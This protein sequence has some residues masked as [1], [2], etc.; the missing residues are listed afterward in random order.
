MP[1]QNPKEMETAQ[2]KDLLQTAAPEAGDDNRG[3]TIVMTGVSGKKITAD[4]KVVKVK[5]AAKRVASPTVAEEEPTESNAAPAS[6]QEPSEKTVAAAEPVAPVQ[7][8][9]VEEKLVSEEKQTTVT[10]SSKPASAPV[11]PVKTESET[12]AAQEGDKAEKKSSTVPIEAE[13]SQPPVEVQTEVEEPK[14]ASTSRS[15]TPKEQPAPVQEVPQS[16]KPTES[17]KSAQKDVSEHTPVEKPVK[18][19]EVASQPPRK[20]APEKSSAKETP[21]QSAPAPTKQA[22]I[23]QQAPSANKSKPAAQ[24]TA[25]AAPAATAATP[26]SAQPAGTKV[27]P[28]KSGLAATAAYF[29]ARAAARKKEAE[30]RIQQAG[31]RGNRNGGG[32]NSG[33][34]SYGNNRGDRNNG[35]RF[36]AKDKDEEPKLQS[37]SRTPARRPNP[38]D[39]EL[40][41]NSKEN[42]RNAFASRDS[43]GRNDR[44]GDRR[45]QEGKSTRSALARGRRYEDVDDEMQRGRR[46]GAKKRDKAAPV[47]HAVLTNITLPEVITVKEFAEAIKKTSA[48]VIK[49]LM[50]LGMM[51]TLNQEIDFDTAAIIAGEFNITAEKLVEVTE[52]DILF[53]ES[54]DREEDLE[55]RPPVV[56]VMGHVDHGKTSLLDYIRSADVAQGE[57]GGITQHIG[58]YMVD[59]NGRKI[60]FLDTPGHEAFTTMRARGAQATDIAILVVAADDGVM[61]Q[62]IEAINHAKA[63]GTQVVVAINKMDRPGANPDRVKEELSQH[64]L[65][66]EEWG[67]TTVMVPV[68]AKTGEGIEDLLEMVLLTADVLELKANPNRQA[69]GIVIE[70]KLDKQRGPVATLLVNRG[71]LR[72]GDTVVM[73]EIVGR[74]RAMTDAKGQQRKEAG[75]SVPVEIIGI[76]EVPTAGDVFYQVENEKV[77]RSLAEK[78]RVQN[79]ERS[80]QGSSRMS[81]DNL[82]SQMEAGEVKDLNLIVKADVQGSVEAVNQ[83]MLKLSNDE[84]KVKIVHSAVGAITES[85]LNLAEVANAIVIGFNVRPSANVA[86]QAKN[87]GIDL[88]L[89]RVIYHAIEEI[90]AA[91]KG[92]LTPKLEEVTLGTVEIRQVFRASN[93]GTIGG[94]YVTHGK[95]VRNCRARLVRDGVQIWDGKLAS[96][97]RFKDDVREVAQGYECG[98]SLE[99][100]ND[101]KEGDLIETY[102][103]QE[104]ERE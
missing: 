57:A 35:P 30:Q 73:G 32:R 29:A 36:S 26:N 65:I 9:S 96:L 75:P 16:V 62:T 19:V 103:M 24:S 81:L 88:R 7:A 27:D 23:P 77:A 61:P 53:D 54:D 51:A 67:G 64:E 98:I 97:K 79:R 17:E 86:D 59:L 4:V 10:G 60:T 5:K 95:V 34:N 58:A 44:R 74:V 47:I 84:V 25:P 46:R 90:E 3:P 39:Q 50:K 83:A 94:G 28:A 99:N 40:L 78:R 13:T 85:D 41:G 2:E 56:C 1:N 104:V 101:I 100:F 70:A 22:P 52:E 14:S 68:S 69:K 91:M 82:F 72:V 48:E 87:A 31:Q 15:E 6:N 20:P 37:H 63:A 45:D 42:S 66:P 11:S 18:P 55:N 92:L 93:I 49:S 33:G 89:Y 8:I 76:P 43:R 80:I 71:T 102:D 38:L 12:P 21:A